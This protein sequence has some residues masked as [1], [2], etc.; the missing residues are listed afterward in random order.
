M[1]GGRLKA[2]LGGGR[3]GPVLPLS[4]AHVVHSGPSFG[5]H[6][7]RLAVDTR[8][9]D[10]CDEETP[11]ECG[12]STPD[13]PKGFGERGP[14][15][16][17][18]MDPPSTA[19]TTVPPPASGL[20][21]PLTA[22]SSYPGMSPNSDSNTFQSTGGSFGVKDCETQVGSTQ[23]VISLDLDIMGPKGLLSQLALGFNGQHELQ[24]SALRVQCSSMEVH[25]RAPES[26]RVQGSSQSSR[27]KD[28]GCGHKAPR[29]TGGG[30]DQGPQQFFIGDGAGIPVEQPR[31]ASRGGAAGEASL[32]DDFA[33]LFAHPGQ[34]RY[35]R[36]AAS[37][38][39]ANDGS[40]SSRSAGQ[41][42]RL[43]S[44]SPASSSHPSSPA[45]RSSG[46]RLRASASE[47]AM[48]Q[49]GRFLA[50]AGGSRGSPAASSVHTVPEE[51]PVSR[52]RSSSPHPPPPPVVAATSSRQGF[53]G[54]NS[55]AKRPGTGPR[56]E[57]QELEELRRKNMRL[58]RDLY[59]SLQALE[60]ESIS[61]SST[62][63]SS[64]ECSPSPSPRSE[65]T[66]HRCLGAPSR[67]PP[68][69]PPPPPR[70]TVTQGGASSSRE[71]SRRRSDN[72][73]AAGAAATGSA[74]R[75]DSRPGS[76]ASSG[77]GMP[78]KPQ[79]ISAC[80][81]SSPQQ[82]KNS[83]PPYQDSMATFSSFDS[84]GTT[85]GNSGAVHG[86]QGGSASKFVQGPAPVARPEACAESLHPN[87][88]LHDS[89]RSQALP[90]R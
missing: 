21:P 88:V 53:A 46:R 20:T 89:D 18:D 44:S 17:I 82:Q 77:H 3:K 16:C 2:A 74:H 56:S 64:R 9:P 72:G 55:D 62:P 48:P 67:Q 19:S 23:L 71:T 10:S 6:E 14:H 8:W 68:P 22:S 12:R 87:R 70:S 32:P 54:S 84:G 47:G 65:P 50:P 24:S 59:E 61:S 35:T 34:P 41:R 49:A 15:F 36:S 60:E 75:S 51:D 58:E 1:L 38:S 66:G 25:H 78:S 57:I 52:S 13:S 73:N 79:A 28:E 39:S 37:N 29:S 43:A 26:A 76:R 5:G 7:T 30:V 4:G 83:E 40:H 90:S 80:V 33:E 11:A 63:S 69:V 27:S 86:V 31:C 85:A 42:R 81:A 45:S